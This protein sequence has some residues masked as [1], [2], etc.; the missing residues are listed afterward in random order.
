MVLS[1]A[2]TE[3]I[4]QE[5]TSIDNGLFPVKLFIPKFTISNI[6][7][8]ATKEMLYFFLTFMHIVESNSIFIL[9]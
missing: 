2:T 8:S 7:L 5:M 3:Q 9:E 4:F 6:K 1:V